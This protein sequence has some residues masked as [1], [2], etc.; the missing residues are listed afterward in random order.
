MSAGD[1]VA[2]GEQVGRTVACIAEGQILAVVVDVWAKQ[3]DIS[4]HSATWTDSGVRDVWQA[5]EL[6]LPIAW[7]KLDGCQYC[8]VLE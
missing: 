1:V 6:Q 7:Y 5:G 2:C 8:V 4:T 3:A